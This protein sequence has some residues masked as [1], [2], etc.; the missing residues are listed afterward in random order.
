MIF[1]GQEGQ[2]KV[3]EVLKKIC[4]ALFDQN[5]SKHN[6]IINIIRVMH[7]AK[8]LKTRQKA[9]LQLLS[10]FNKGTCFSF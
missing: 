10:P 9:L 5:T 8:V 2:R 6:L 4:I 7:N 1:D 3:T